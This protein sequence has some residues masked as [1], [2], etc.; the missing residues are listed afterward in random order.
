MHTHSQASTDAAA[1]PN[2]RQRANPPSWM[3]RTVRTLTFV[4]AAT[5]AMLGIHETARAQTEVATDW[6]LVPSGLVAGNQFRLL[7]VSSTTRDATSTSIGDYNSHVQSAAAAGHADIP[8][9]SS[10]FKAVACTGSTDATSNTSTTGTGV[11]IY[12]L[13]GNKVADDY[14]DFYDGSWD[15][16]MN[17]KNESGTAQAVLDSAMETDIF[18]GCENAGTRHFSYNLGS[19]VVSVAIPGTPDP[20]VTGEL[21]DSDGNPLTGDST[22]GTQTSQAASTPSPKSS[23]SSPSPPESPPGSPSAP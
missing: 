19:T 11:P 7:F 6:S 2:R 10:G 20:A 14:A 22:S 16:E 18:T 23:K 1:T 15:D 8:S 4:L 5:A 12:W 21:N 9:H 17:P 3:A 13:N